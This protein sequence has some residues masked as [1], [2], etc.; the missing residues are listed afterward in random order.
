MAIRK[1]G[2]SYQIDL[3]VNGIRKSATRDTE[4]AAILAEAEMKVEMLKSSPANP[5]DAWTLK[6]CYE[7]CEAQVWAGTPHG[8]NVA[9]IYPK[10]EKHFGADTP[11]VEIT[12]GSIDDYCQALRKRGKANGTIN[13]HTAV[14]SKLFSYAMER[15]DISKVLAKPHIEHY[16]EPIGR[17][18]YFTVAEEKA[19]TG[20]MRHLGYAEQADFV[21]FLL[22]TGARL[23][24]DGLKLTWDCVDF[25]ANL[26][27]FKA[28][29]A[30]NTTGI[31][32]TPRVKAM[33]ERMHTS[34]GRDALR[35]WPHKYWWLRG[36]WMRVATALGKQ[37]DSEWIPHT[38]RHTTA[39]RLVQRGVDLRAVQDFMGHKT[40]AVT[41]RYA[42]LAPG[43]LSTCAAALAH[44]D[45]QPSAAEPTTDTKPPSQVAG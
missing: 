39:S 8:K 23:E 26:I 27:V 22:D 13:R 42:H 7:R 37:E 31:P 34:P 25:K 17:Q 5:Q 35:V 40:L 41:M 10:L 9:K 38:C 3:S 14:L 18:R 24:S 21:E 2:N 28:R 30:R 33:L 4:E 45:P 6:E 44:E 19:I 11:M 1:R 36:P 15:A 20:H 29:K 32:M 12:G 16:K 43:S